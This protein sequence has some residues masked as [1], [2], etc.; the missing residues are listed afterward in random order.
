MKVKVKEWERIDCK[1]WADE[2]LSNSLLDFLPT[3][4]LVQTIATKGANSTYPSHVKK[5][6]SVLMYIELKI[7]KILRYFISV[8][9]MN[10]AY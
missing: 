10:C 5:Q 8:Y 3:A 2:V 6:I 4:M 9:S 7:V 1:P